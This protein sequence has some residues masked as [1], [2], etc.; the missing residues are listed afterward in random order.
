VS[1]VIVVDAELLPETPKA[2]Q[3]YVDEYFQEKTVLGKRVFVAS[4]VLSWSS[5]NSYGHRKGQGT[6]P[7]HSLDLRRFTEG[8][9]KDEQLNEWI[10][11][12]EGKYLWQFY[13]RDDSSSCGACDDD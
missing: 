4:T 12:A 5:Y 6:A 9:G 11:K 8:L 7:S 1:S 10:R 2:F 3:Q 13:G